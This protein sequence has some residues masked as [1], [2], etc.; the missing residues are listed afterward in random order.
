MDEAN[1]HSR[2][3]L[4]FSWMTL[5]LMM[6]GK[7]FQ[8][9]CKMELRGLLSQLLI[10]VVWARNWYILVLLWVERAM[11]KQVVKWGIIWS[12]FTIT[13]WWGLAVPQGPCRAGQGSAGLCPVLFIPSV[14][15][16]WAFGEFIYS[17]NPNTAYKLCF[18]N[19]Y[20]AQTLFFSCIQV[21]TR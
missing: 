1:T 5:V 2:E 19:S 8:S 13:A 14:W 17:R 7:R 20:L 10:L 18:L 16:L 15:T 11:Q 3:S 6:V 21:L 9:W 4:V 12:D